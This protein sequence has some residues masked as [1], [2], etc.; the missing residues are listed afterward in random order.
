MLTNE[1]C[2]CQIL[3][4]SA[5]GGLENSALIAKWAQQQGKM[6]VVSAAFE[7][8]LGLSAYTLFSCYLELQK[9]NISTMMGSNLPSSIAHGLGTYQWLKEDTTSDS[10]AVSFSP[11][12]GS[13]AA[14]VADAS[15]I[16]QNVQMN[17]HIIS[18]T[19]CEEHVR[20]YNLNVD[21]AGSTFL[22]KVLEL[23]N[24]LEVRTENISNYIFCT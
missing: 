14:S 18:R 1:Y 4:P 7:S 19:S 24:Q 13:I 5:L 12:N 6:A 2:D 16:L 21:A 22:V 8:S 15:R 11:H 9:A 23:G 3:K 17:R 10:L 20:S